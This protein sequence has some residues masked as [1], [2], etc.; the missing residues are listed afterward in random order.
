MESQ[1]STFVSWVNELK[2]NASFYKKY[3]RRNANF[4]LCLVLYFKP[5]TS[6]LIMKD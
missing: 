2:Y 6:D 3:K 5:E 4:N 1:Q